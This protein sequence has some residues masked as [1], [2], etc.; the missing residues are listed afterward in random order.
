MNFILLRCYNNH[1]TISKLSHIHDHFT[2][3]SKWAT[4]LLLVQR[5]PHFVAKY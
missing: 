4:R 1:D 5:M 3:T 2:S